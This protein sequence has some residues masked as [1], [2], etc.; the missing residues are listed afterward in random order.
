MILVGI[1]RTYNKIYTLDWS[2]FKKSRK[3]KIKVDVPAITPEM[4]EADITPTVREV[5]AVSPDADQQD[6]I[7]TERELPSVV[8]PAPP[9]RD[10]DQ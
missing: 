9:N 10:D 5:P 4:L 3:M 1:F 2:T 6:N 7:K 8:P